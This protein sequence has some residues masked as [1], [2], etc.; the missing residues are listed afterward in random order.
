MRRFSVRALALATMLCVAVFAPPFARSSDM[1]QHLREYQNKMFILRSFYQ[2]S[3]FHFDSEGNLREP[4]VPGDW[5]VEGVVRVENVSLSGDHLKIRASRL[6]LGW[7]RTAG[8]EEV[9][10]YDGQKLDKNEKKNRSIEIDAELSTAT[11]DATDAA[12]ARIFLSSQDTFTD[13][14][15][16]YWK[17]CVRNAV[18]VADE[19]DFNSCR[20]SAE[21][22]AVPGVAIPGTTP[23]SDSR[24]NPAAPR[25]IQHLGSPRRP[26]QAP[27]D[28]VFRVGR[29]V[30]PPR[31]VSQPGV[32][33]TDYARKA[34]FQGVVT[35]KLV[36]DRSGNPTDVRILSPLGCGLDAQAV[37][38]VESWKFNPGTKDGE[39]VAV[40]IAV[41]TDFH[42]Y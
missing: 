24:A 31:V 21:L 16:D 33:F 17:P 13:L 36:V 35:L 12:F 2:G 15:P 22:L 8:L 39:P 18:G 11:A 38:T 40:E 9:H 34:K 42:L 28:G 30:T 37:R 23:P 26:P 4:A 20:F 32:E 10:D 14:V 5:T 1:D 7:D 25:E 6:H 29:G 3:S 41:E 19:K 27:P